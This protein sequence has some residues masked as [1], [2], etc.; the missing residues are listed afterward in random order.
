MDFSPPGFSVHGISQARI[1][2][3]VAISFSRGSSRPRNWTQVSCIAG[4]FSTD[5]TTRESF[6]LLLLAQ[7]SV[8]SCLPQRK[9]PSS[10]MKIEWKLWKRSGKKRKKGEKNLVK[11]TLSFP[12]TRPPLGVP[13][14]YTHMYGYMHIHI[15]TQLPSVTTFHLEPPPFRQFADHGQDGPSELHS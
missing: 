8:S 15:Q 12:F 13:P 3:W 5:W 2:E 7:L 1:L 11:I 10:A 4:R 14:T 6:F 9:L